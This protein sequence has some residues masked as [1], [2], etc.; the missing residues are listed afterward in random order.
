VF[1][2]GLAQVEK[3]LGED[4]EGEFVSAPPDRFDWPRFF[5]LQMA[6]LLLWSAVERFCALSYGPAL[7]PWQKVN[8][9]GGDP[10]F[11]SNLLKI[12]DRRGSVVDSRDP[13]DKSKLDVSNP[14]KSAQYYYQVRSNL[15]HRGKAANKDGEIVRRSLIELLSIFR[16]MLESCYSEEAVPL[17]PDQI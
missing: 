8:R 17:D 15:S 10:R 4:G 9:L 16:N 12:V 1:S 11:A 5:R 2:Y 13:K 7:E 6:Y 3:I 14:I